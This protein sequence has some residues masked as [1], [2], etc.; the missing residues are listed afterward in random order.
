M[1]Y[2]S[3]FM[4]AFF[5]FAGQASAQV[6]AISQYFDQYVDDDRFTVVY[7]S[8]R[9]FKLFAQAGDDNDDEEEREVRQAIKDLKGLRILTTEETPRKF[10][11][12]AKAKINTKGY[13]V[14]MTVKSKGD[15]DVEFLIKENGDDIEELLLLVGGDESFV[16]MSFVG[17]INLEQL[18]KI[19]DSMDIEGLEH[20]EE[21]E[22]N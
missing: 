13:E 6:D 21:L 11:K 8:S 4:I 20:L 15:D 1:K 5:C 7:I 18:S 10:Y 14:L 3:I 2:V 9:M 12:E 16:M 17:K 19:S 22:K